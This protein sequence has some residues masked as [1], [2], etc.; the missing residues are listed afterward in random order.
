MTIKLNLSLFTHIV[1]YNAKIL[2]PLL[3]IIDQINSGI[4]T[5]HYIV[6]VII[7]VMI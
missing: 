4:P 1:L 6:G 2:L 7:I 3:V 5:L